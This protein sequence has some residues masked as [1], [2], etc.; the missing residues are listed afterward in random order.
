MLKLC[1]HISPALLTCGEFTKSWDHAWFVL[2]PPKY[3]LQCMVCMF[4]ETFKSSSSRPVEAAH[5]QIL[6]QEV[7]LE[8]QG[9]FSWSWAPK[10]SLPSPWGSNGEVSVGRDAPGGG[11]AASELR[12]PLL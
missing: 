5:K 9:T 7:Q 1:V 10:A 3:P 12:T 11:R 6:S 4:S 2:Q 8:G